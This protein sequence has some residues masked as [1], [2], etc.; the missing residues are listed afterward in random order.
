MQPNKNPY[1]F[2]TNPQTN[3]KK[4]LLGGNDTKSRIIVVAIIAAVVLILFIIGYNLLFA[5]KKSF[6]DEMVKPAAQQTDLIEITTIGAEKV[7]DSKTNKIMTTAS[8]V[9]QSQNQ[10]TLIILKD[11]GISSKNIAQFQDKKYAELL[12]S[13]EASGNFEQTYVGIYQNR[14]DEYANNLKVAYSKA[15]GKYK[16]EIGAMYKQLEN[17]SLNSENPNN[18]TAPATN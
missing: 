3:S 18:S 7:R 17:L 16:E 2:I 13:A 11:N 1:E 4:S 8:S 9:I 6:A 10:K 14:L 5:G 12:A 15:S